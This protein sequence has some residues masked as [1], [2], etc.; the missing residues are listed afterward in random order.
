[1]V[2]Y[3]DSNRVSSVQGRKNEVTKLLHDAVEAEKS[4]K[5][6]VYYW[7]AKKA[8]IAL[9]NAG[10]KLPE[11]LDNRGFIR[12]IHDADSPVNSQFIDQTETKQLKRWFGKSK[13]VNEDGTPCIVYHG[14]SEN[15]TA[16]DMSKGRANM[17]IQGA[18]FSPYKE[19]AAGYGDNVGAYYL[20]IQN[21]ASESVA[22]AA[23]NKFKGQNG[24]GIKAREY[25]E[26]QGYDG[27]YNG[28]DEYIAFRPNQI[29]SATDNKGT[30]FEESNDTRY[31]YTDQTTLPGDEVLDRML[32]ERIESNVQSCECTLQQY[33]TRATWEL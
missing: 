12:S 1:M 7:D 20:S 9:K 33:S 17:D 3:Y 10:V 4:G 31:R 24:A 8:S 5:T 13:V 25:Q 27:V 16:Y 30:F 11:I 29:K 22:Y 23:L 2:E 6:A 19:D 15:F 28:Y 26:S 32:R 21:P 18:F 14:T